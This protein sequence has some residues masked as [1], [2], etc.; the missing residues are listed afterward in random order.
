MNIKNGL[1][2]IFLFFC[3]IKGSSQLKQLSFNEINFTAIQVTFNDNGTPIS[4]GT[5]FM[6]NNKGAFY[7][8]TNYHVINANRYSPTNTVR[9]RR[10]FNKSLTIRFQTRELGR[11]VDSTYD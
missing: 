1:I 6:V 9:K 5:A 3:S 7:L 4:S 2:V 11:F 8:L 10:V